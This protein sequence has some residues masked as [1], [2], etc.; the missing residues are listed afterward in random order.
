MKIVSCPDEI[1]VVAGNNIRLTQQGYVETEDKS[2][3][4]FGATVKSSG[5]NGVIVVSTQKPCS[6]CRLKH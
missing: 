6:V 2:N 4:W 1:Y 3:Q 5:E